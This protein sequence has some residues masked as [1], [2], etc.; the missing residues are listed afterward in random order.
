M[1]HAC[2]VW[3]VIASLRKPFGGS[4]NAHARDFG[5]VLQICSP[6]CDNPIRG[7]LR[8]IMDDCIVELIVDVDAQHIDEA[9][10][11]SARVAPLPMPPLK[12]KM[13]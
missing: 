9:V 6:H 3:L 11:Q 1:L 4:Y 2:V 7:R 13:R 10:A 8:D 12:Q 5:F